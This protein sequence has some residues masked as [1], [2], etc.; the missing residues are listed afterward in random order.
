MLSTRL[1][2]PV[3]RSESWRRLRLQLLLCRAPTRHVSACAAQNE[4]SSSKNY[5]GTKKGRTTTKKYADLPSVYINASGVA[6]A[7]LPEWNP[8]YIV[9][10]PPSEPAQ[11]QCAAAV[12]PRSRTRKKANNGV[13]S[14]HSLFTLSSDTLYEDTGPRAQRGRLGPS[15]PSQL[16]SSADLN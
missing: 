16:D 2:V 7:P 5:E 12:K 1:S 4:T 6:A 13:S 9:P 15:K 10:P 11:L 3:S 14:S 8:N